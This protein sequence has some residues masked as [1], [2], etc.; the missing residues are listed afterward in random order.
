MAQQTVVSQKELKRQA[1]LCFEGRTVYVMLC[2]FT[3]IAPTP[4]DTVA[5]WQAL[6]VSGNGYTRFSGTIGIGSYV[7]LNGSYD[8]PVVTATFLA[9]GVGYTYS[10]LVV[11]FA[12]ETYPHS[13]ITESPN[14]VL[15]AGQAQTY[16]I[17]LAQDD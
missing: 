2:S 11:Y 8:L 16:Q 12:G 1:E 13:I 9:T 15:L 7:A 10:H 4:E 6:E 17:S 5:T 14:I 3:G